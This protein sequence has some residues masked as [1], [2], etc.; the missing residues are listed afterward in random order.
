M[1]VAGPARCDDEELDMEH[2]FA[3]LQ[4]PEA[5]NYGDVE[6]QE[7]FKLACDRA[8]ARDDWLT[9][10]GRYLRLCA[11]SAFVS[12]QLTAEGHEM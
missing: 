7:T 11:L 5:H 4:L 9:L 6:G 8:V 3:S 12:L 10:E 1:G 2:W